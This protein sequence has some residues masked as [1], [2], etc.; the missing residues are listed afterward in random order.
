MGKDLKVKLLVGFSLLFFVFLAL[1]YRSDYLIFFVSLIASIIQIVLFLVWYFEDTTLLKHVD[2]NVEKIKEITL[3]RDEE[4]IYRQK[5][6]RKIVNKG[7]IDEEEIKKIIA[8]LEKRDMVLVSLSESKI[9]KGLSQKDT[10]QYPLRNLL[11]DMGFVQ[12]FFTYYADM[13]NIWAIPKSELPRS[14]RKVDSLKSFII[15][16]LMGN[17]L[18]IK[19]Y[20]LKNYPNKYD[21]WK[22][23]DG[24]KVS[25]II[26]KSFENDFKID[27]LGRHKFNEGFIAKLLQKSS[28]EELNKVISDKV[29]VREILS[30]LSIDLFLERVSP[31]I[32]DIILKNEKKIILNLNIKS[33]LDYR[34]IDM[35]KLCAEFIKY[36]SQQDAEQLTNI[37]CTEANNYYNEIEKMGLLIG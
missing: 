35:P 3:Q 21:K 19:N 16:V 22:S 25:L 15:K 14:L 13:G 18:S 17:R 24:F 32:R 20:A 33:F 12:V 34:N 30:K 29:A 8:K 27:Y 31:Q 10:L 2:L 7:K 4:N 6:I 1:K 36:I 23:D 37:V 9:P 11:K 28:K 5:I 26:G